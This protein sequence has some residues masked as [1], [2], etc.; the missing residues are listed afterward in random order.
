M[1]IIVECHCGYQQEVENQHTYRQEWN[2]DHDC[3]SVEKI[4]NW[5]N[6]WRTEMSKHKPECDAKWEYDQDYCICQWIEQAEERIIKILNDTVDNY[7]SEKLLV[8]AAVIANA[9]AYIKE[10]K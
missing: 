2:W 5:I 9:I 10:N 7:L 6:Q 4:V 3:M 8:E 1:S